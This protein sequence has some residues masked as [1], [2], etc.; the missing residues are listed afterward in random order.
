MLRLRRRVFQSGYSKMSTTQACGIV[1]LVT[2]I[3]VVG[4]YL[5]WKLNAWQFIRARQLIAHWAMDNRYD[6]IRAEY[7]FFSLSLFYLMTWR[8]QHVYRITVIDDNGNQKTG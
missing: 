7:V 2:M 6:L 3:I 5:Y 4:G 1:L 8:G